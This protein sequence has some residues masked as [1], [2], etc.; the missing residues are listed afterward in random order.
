MS[1]GISDIGQLNFINSL[2]SSQ[3]KQLN[4]IQDQISSGQKGHVYG[5]LG[6]AGSVSSITL[7]NSLSQ[8]DMFSTNVSL[9]RGRT[10]VMASALDSITSA[11][12]GV[13]SQLLTATQSATDPGMANFRVAARGALDQILSYLNGQYAGEQVFAGT[14][15]NTR[16][17][18]SA[19][20]LDASINAQLANL[21]SGASTGA[22]VMTNINALSGA[23]A[24]YSATLAASG[25]MTAQ[26]DTRQFVDYTVKADDPAIQSLVKGLGVI[27]NLQYD[28][29][30]PNEFWTVFNSAK[31]MI[32]QG[33]DGVVN[34][35]AKV[36]LV[37][38]QLDQVDQM[39]NATNTILQTQLG[40]I[41][42]VDVAQ[43]ASQ[44]QLLQTQL[45]ASY[46]VSSIV[47]QLSLVNYL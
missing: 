17:I 34:L 2:L 39:H 10:S 24:G 18:A 45:Q 7:H 28:P 20:A 8:L 19:A 42:N 25:G 31:Q 12:Q 14:D 11:A 23:A 41:E 27:A 3:R 44:L 26:I 43:A 16:P 5:D 4:D 35:H 33:T 46:K 30:H 21:Y 29:A 6:G 40:D 22:T 15:V 9:V 47:S 32:D 13:S 36:G 38:N 37:Q 1:F